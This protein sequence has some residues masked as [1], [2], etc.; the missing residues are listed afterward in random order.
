MYSNT[1]GNTSINGSVAADARCG[2]NLKVF[3]QLLTDI[4]TAWYLAMFVDVNTLTM[5]L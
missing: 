5:G 1:S 2:Y 4:T 3:P